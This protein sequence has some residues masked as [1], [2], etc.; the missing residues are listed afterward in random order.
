LIK[1]YNEFKNQGFVVIGINVRE[2]KGIVKEYIDKYKL[3]FPV[4]LDI[5]GTVINKYGVRVH[6][7][8][9]LVNKR[10]ELIGK[11]LGPRNWM[12]AKNRDLIRFLLGQD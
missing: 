6:P 8:H 10:G 11:T 3:T 5:H 2:G 1:L 4:T 7:E 12:D 9:F